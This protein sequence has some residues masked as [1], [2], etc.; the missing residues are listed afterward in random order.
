MRI[1]RGSALSVAQPSHRDASPA[2]R[3]LRFEIDNDMTQGLARDRR[4]RRGAAWAVRRAK[5]SRSLMRICMRSRHCACARDNRAPRH[6]ARCHCARRGNPR[7]P[8]SCARALGDHA[9]RPR[10]T[11]AG[12][13]LLRVSSPVVA[14]VG[15][16]LRFL[17]SDV[18]QGDRQVAGIVR[19]IGDRGP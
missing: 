11:L 19:G 9:R 6:P 13:R 8:G 18:P 17:G 2:P 7:M 16:L 4:E 1:W 15:L 12:P 14:M 3:D 10:Q 5:V